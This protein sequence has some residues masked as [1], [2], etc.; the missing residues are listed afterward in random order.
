MDRVPLPRGN[1]IEIRLKSKVTAAEFEK[2]KK[3]LDLS[4][5][6]FVMSNDDQPTEHDDQ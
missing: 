5:M 3:L 4:E 6:S 1:V 2:I